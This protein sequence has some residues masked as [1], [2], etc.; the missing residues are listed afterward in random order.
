MKS[1]KDLNKVTQENF[2]K[3][4]I[5]WIKLS[6]RIEGKYQIVKNCLI[7]IRR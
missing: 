4:Q 2:P 7:N 5:W 1:S 3:W 6:A